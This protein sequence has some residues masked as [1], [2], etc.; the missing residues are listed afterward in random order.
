MNREQ[1]LKMRATK[2]VSVDVQ[3]F[4]EVKMREL[5]ESLRV[6]EFDTWLRPGDKIHKQRQLDARLKIISLCVVG[7]GNRPFNND[8]GVD[9]LNQIDAAVISRASSIAMAVLGLSDEDVESKLKK[10]SDD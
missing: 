7:E 6:R 10:T 5:P 1:F 2:T 4:G 8:E 9:F 3:G